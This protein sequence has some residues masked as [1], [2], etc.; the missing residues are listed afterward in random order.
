MTTE[1]TRTVG[2]P[3]DR[4]TRL[5]AVMTDALEADPEYADDVRA[6][7]FLNTGARGG[8]VLHGY[9]KDSDAVADVLVHLTAVLEANGIRLELIGIPDT[10]AGAE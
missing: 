7:V 5:V 8:A 3:H 6:A 4:L 2:Q 10:V 1:P 9:E